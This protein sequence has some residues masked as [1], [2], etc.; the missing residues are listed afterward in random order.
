MAKTTLSLESLGDLDGGAAGAVINAAINSAVADLDDRG[1]DLQERKVV[2]TLLMKKL[3]NKQIDQRV[4]VQTSV[5]A[6]ATNSTFAD[7]ARKGDRPAIYF[8]DMNPSRPD[9]PTFS[10]LDRDRDERNGDA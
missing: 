1:E 4:K 9:Q 10:A 7:I 8:Q 5:P 6:Y 3:P 2:I